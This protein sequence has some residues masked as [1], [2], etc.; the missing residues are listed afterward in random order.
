[1]PIF[2]ND[3]ILPICG[4]ALVRV[5][6]CSLCSRL[7]LK[8]SAPL[9]AQIGLDDQLEPLPQ[10]NKT[11]VS[12]KLSLNSIH[13]TWMIRSRL[14]RWMFFKFK[15]CRVFFELGK[16]CQLIH[17]N[18]SWHTEMLYIFSLNQAH[19]AN[20]VIESRCPSVCLCVCLRHRMQFFPRPLIGPEIT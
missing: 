8:C 6:A 18:Y 7:V 11:L 1:M 19:W 4:D 16:Q 3:W 9:W 12:L 20:S 15:T 14:F 10:L 17:P 2:L 5:F 13:A